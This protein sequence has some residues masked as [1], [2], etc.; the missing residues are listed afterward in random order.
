M[1]RRPRISVS[2]VPQHVIQRGNNRQPTFFADEDY[3]FYLDCLWE[4]AAKHGCQVHNYVL[5]TN[6]VHLLV[7][8]M[9]AD[10]L[11]R[12]MQDVGRR[13]V[14]QRVNFIYRRSGTLWEGRY[15]ACLVDARHYF[16]T[17]CRYIELNPV[18]AGMVGQPEDYRWSS[19]LHY[20][21]GRRE[22][23]LFLH[24][25]Y[26]ALGSTPSARQ[27]AYRALFGESF[28]ARDVEE[29]RGTINRGWPLG[30]ERFKDEIEVALKRAV[31][32]PKR[33][34]PTMKCGPDPGPDPN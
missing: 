5:M 19:H 14:Q 6:H 1:A 25:E 8:P 10:A 32:P 4:A 21:F 26:Q 12:T 28:D 15:K 3:R 31:R 7:T 16:L 11:S 17:C 18:R 2:G 30:G 34:R 29:I 27:D 23:H 24:R 22:D 33:G 13:F 9:N 20:A